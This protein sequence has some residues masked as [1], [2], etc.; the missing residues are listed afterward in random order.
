MTKDEAIAAVAG[1]WW[2]KVL[3]P[4]TKR[5]FLDTQPAQMGTGHR[6]Q[7]A[8][9]FARRARCAASASRRR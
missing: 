9:A 6:A 4:I 7:D 1:F 5:R 3:P 2:E 8:H